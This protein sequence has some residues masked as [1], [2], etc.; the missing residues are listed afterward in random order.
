MAD[1]AIQVDQVWKRFHKG[2][3]EDSLRDL[4][5]TLISRLFGR[6]RESKFTQRAFWALEDISFEVERGESIGVIGPNGAGKSTLLKLLCGIIRQTKGHYHCAGRVSALIEVGAGFH[7]DLTGREN[8]Y[9]NG[10]ILGMPKRVIAQKEEEIIDFAGVSEFIDTPVKRYSSGMRARLGFSVAAHL[11]PDILLVDEVLSVGDVR[12]RHKCIQH[13]RKLINGDVTVLFISHLLDQVR[14]LCPNT[15]VLD[16]GRMVY[17]GETEGAISKYLEVVAEDMSVE[18][19]DGLPTEVKVEVQNIVFRNVEGDEVLN[20]E[21]GRPAII[22]CEL[23]NHQHNENLAIMMNINTI[24]G[25]YVGTAHSWRHVELPAEKGRH[26]V[27]FLFDPMPLSDGDFSMEMRVQ[28]IHKEGES[29][30]CLWAMKH[31][32]AFTISGSGIGTSLIRCD[33]HWTVEATHVDRL[34]SG[35]AITA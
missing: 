19:D 13:M 12:F 30:E 18:D 32:R 33:G 23:V 9:L 29:S 16:K 28:Q 15:I 20:W 10:A 31:P 25:I 2:E 8:I 26:V 4:I 24:A 21:G 6:K 35:N 3:Y 5:P 22:E 14:S 1:Y 27:R 7:P 11:E 34:S 17:N